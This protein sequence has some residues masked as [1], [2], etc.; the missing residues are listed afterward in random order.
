MDKK[1]NNTAFSIWILTCLTGAIL[2]SFLSYYKWSRL[3]DA[4]AV[5]V[6][7]LPFGCFFSFYVYFLLRRLFKKIESKQLNSIRRIALLGIIA[8]CLTFL[9][10]S[11]VVCFFMSGSF[12]YNLF[13][14]VI[15]FY[16]FLSVVITIVLGENYFRKIQK[17]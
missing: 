11:P 14:N 13:I 7:Y 5:F 17:F 6:F 12:L 3:S 10:F 2:M 1:R 4:F 8:I 9:S 16:L 15:V